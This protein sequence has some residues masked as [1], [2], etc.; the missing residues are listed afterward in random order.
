V[1]TYFLILAK[2]LLPFF[3]FN[4][5]IPSIYMCTLMIKDFNIRH[6]F[7]N[8]DILVYLW[9]HMTTKNLGT[10]TMVSHDHEKLGNSTKNYG[11]T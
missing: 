9:C 11:V 1:Y 8:E 3:Y 5:N 7:N 6:I 2:F 10:P 4:I